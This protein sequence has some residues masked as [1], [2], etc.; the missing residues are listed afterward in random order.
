MPSA[1]RG[2]R[3]DAAE[4]SLEA[5]PPMR[6]RLQGLPAWAHVEKKRA[7]HI[8][9]VVELLERWAE[10]LDLDADERARWA[11]AGWL[12]DAVKDV[13][14]PS[15]RAMVP[16]SMKRLPAKLLHGHAAAERARRDG[17]HDEELL[18]A[19][20]WHTTGHPDLG[21]LGRALYLADFL[22][23]GRTFDPAM[24]ER[25]RARMPHD[26]EGVLA[27]VLSNRIHKLEADDVEVH[28]QTRAFHERVSS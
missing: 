20:R 13:D 3:I 14:T 23:P 10:A 12:H 17:L 2:G 18:E 24:T 28:P 1:P 7:R 22:E 21:R 16:P 25:L 9:R 15:L 26:M 5:A 19:V 27:E 4:S 8:E 6:V 11:T